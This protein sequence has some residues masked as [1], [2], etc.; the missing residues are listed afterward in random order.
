MHL[1][2]RRRLLDCYLH[3]SPEKYVGLY[4]IDQAPVVWCTCRRSH[5]RHTDVAVS[6]DDVLQRQR[7]NLQGEHCFAS[8]PSLYLYFAPHSSLRPTLAGGCDH[9]V[10]SCTHLRYRLSLPRLGRRRDELESASCVKSVISRI[11][12]VRA[13]KTKRYQKEDLDASRLLQ[14]K[15]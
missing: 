12:C 10:L 13:Q 11:D 8:M 7:K 5:F 3:C 9:E 4:S 6:P 1:A 14:M 2:L 15:H